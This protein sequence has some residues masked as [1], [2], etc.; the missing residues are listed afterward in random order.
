MPFNID[1]LTNAVTPTGQA[2]Q[3]TYFG[4]PP[5]NL[6]PG[7]V[8]ATSQQAMSG[9]N[10]FLQ[11]PAGSNLFQSTLSG[12]FN[13]PHLLQAEHSARQGL[14]DQF[15][16]AGNLASGQ[17]GT[18]SGHLESDIL[19][20]RQS[21]AANLLSQL[22]PQE[23]NAMLA[24]GNQL[25]QLLNALKLSQGFGANPSV[26]KQGGMDDPF[27]ML[28]QF[29]NPAGGSPGPQFGGPQVSTIPGGGNQGG[30]S[31]GG[32]MDI[33]SLIQILGG[34]RGAPSSAPTSPIPNSQGTSYFGGGENNA[35]NFGT[36]PMGNQQQSQPFDQDALMNI[37]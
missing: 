33:N 18:A 28:S 21:T 29:N 34:M 35:W 23:T 25:V 9:Y 5:P 37:L 30:G 22:F 24:P 32:G 12:F 1:A 13:N 17:F 20:N 31:P 36:D 27:G 8:G 7:N 4:K 10:Q 6:D 14:Q 11:N 19:G 2:S 3:A 16:S 15:R 26:G